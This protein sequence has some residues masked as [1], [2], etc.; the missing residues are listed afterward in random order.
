MT[1]AWAVFLNYSRFRAAEAAL[2]IVVA[3]ICAGVLLLRPRFARRMLAPPKWLAKRRGLAVLTVAAV[4]VLARVLLL[5]AVPPRQ[6][7]THDEYIHLLVADTLAHGRL[8]NPVHPMWQHLDTIY[9][10]QYPSYAAIYPIGEGAILAVGQILT[11]SP[12]AGHVLSLALMTAAAWWMLCG[13]VE[14]EWA[15][16]GGL[17]AGLVY[18]VTGEW[19]TTYLGAPVAAAGGA[20]V[21]GA[22]PRFQARRGAGCAVVMAIGWSAIW[23]TRPAGAAVVAAAIAVWM[24]YSMLREPRGLWMRR[25]AAMTAVLLAT[26]GITLMHDWRVTG[27]PLELPYELARAEYGVPQSFLGQKVVPPPAA[28]RFADIRAMYLMQRSY[29]ESMSHPAYLARETEGRLAAVWRFFVNSYFSLPILLALWVSRRNLLLMGLAALCVLGFLEDAIYPFFFIRYH[30]PYWGIYVLLAVM[31]LRCLSRWA[32]GR[33]PWGAF[34]AIALACFGACNSLRDVESWYAGGRKPLMVPPPRYAVQ[35]QLDAIPGKHLVLVRYG[36]HHNLLQEWIYNRA[37][38]D[39][40]KI[41]WAREIDTDKDRELLHYF[42]SRTVWYVNADSPMPVQAHPF[43]PLPEEP[44]IPEMFRSQ[45]DGGN[46]GQTSE[47]PREPSG[48]FQIFG[49]RVAF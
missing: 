23:L 28:F 11:G 36:P 40:S 15:L 18:G 24:L 32:P 13:W 38:I 39:S 8:A 19:A 42:A 49:K 9:V 20:L 7:I 34:L 17:L 47:L 16:M 33:R 1:F 10:L 2:S 41:V 26:A 35:Q 25:L 37:D 14:M 30:A 6:P 46:A 21:F 48:A 29:R 5:P 44:R 22:L 43:G 31:G 4:P 27:N 12:W 3:A 45:L